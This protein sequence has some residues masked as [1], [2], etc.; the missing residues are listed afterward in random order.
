MSL[1]PPKYLYLKT[2]ETKIKIPGFTT[3]K[4]T[5]NRKYNPKEYESEAKWAS[6]IDKWSHSWKQ[7][8]RL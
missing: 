1:K 4:L 8:Q 5:N 7:V 3:I 6:H 2:K